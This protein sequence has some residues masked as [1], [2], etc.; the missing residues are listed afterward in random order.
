MIYEY[1][2]YY[3]LVNRGCNRELIFRDDSDY[4]ELIKRMKKSDHKSYVKLI[5][6]CLMP[7]HYHLLV[8]QISEKSASRWLGFVF[9]GYSHYFN[10]KYER[11]GTIFESRVRTRLITDNIYLFRVIQYIHLNP[12]IAGMVSD[13]LDWDFSNYA[14]WIG[15]TKSELTDYEFIDEFFESGEE[16][17]KILKEVQEDKLLQQKFNE[18][19]IELK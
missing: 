18:S 2:N 16:Y 4:L 17:R 8:Q 3:H 14:D 5:A 13:P 11:T 1:G 15:S 10:L 7:N 9:N 12:V 6:W 19:K